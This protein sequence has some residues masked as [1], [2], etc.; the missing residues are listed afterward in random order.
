ELTVL[1]TS[2]EVLH[3]YGE[4]GFPVAPLAQAPALALFVERAQAVNPGFRLTGANAAAVAELCAGLDGLPLALALAAAQTRVRTPQALVARCENRLGLLAGGARDLP[5][6]Q[7]T[8]RRTIDWSHQLLS[9][10][11]KAVFRRLALFAGGF[12]LEAAQAVVDPFGSLDLP[13]ELV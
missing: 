5:G 7:R 8:L 11:E 6:R 13:L 3:L 2:R 10:T 1:V 4:H 12:T 9:E